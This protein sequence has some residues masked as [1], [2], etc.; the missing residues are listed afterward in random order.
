[1]MPRPT[2]VPWRCERPPRR[3]SGRHP[4]PSG[5]L[6]RP[7]HARRN[8]R[9]ILGVRHR[10]EAYRLECGTWA[11][12]S[13]ATVRRLPTVAE[14]LTYLSKAARKALA[15]THAARWRTKLAAAG[16]LTGKHGSIGYMQS[17]NAPPSTLVF[18]KKRIPA[19]LNFHE[20]LVSLPKERG[21]TQSVSIESSIPRNTMKEAPRR[22]PAS[23]SGGS[24]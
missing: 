14:R 21:L 12:C 15:P 19:E 16:P 10:S 7:V 1:M 24:R 23:D 5:R 18:V 3:Y 17:T 6:P 4:S 8:A 9:R 11:S 13:T 22:F 20:R 2:C